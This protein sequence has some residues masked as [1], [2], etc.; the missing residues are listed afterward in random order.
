MNNFEL[1]AKGS[2]APE[3]TG[4]GGYA[5]LP[6]DLR[7]REI[8]SA[9]SNIQNPPLSENDVIPKLGTSCIFNGT[10][11]MGK[12]TLLANLVSDERFYGYN[13]KMTFDH[14]FLFSPTAEGDDVQKKY[15]IDE[16]NTFT[17]LL[18]APYIIG[19]IMEEQKKMVKEYGSD[20][21]PQ[22]L[23]IYDDVISNPDFMRADEFI[24]SF[25]ASRHYNLTTMIC[26]QSWTAVPRRCRLQARNIFF[27]ASPQS[28]VELLALEHCPPRYSKK[29]F[30]SLVN[31]A[32]Y[33]PY[34][35]L[36]IN[37]SAQMK[38]RYHK[39]LDEIIDL[40]AFRKRVSQNNEH[41]SQLDDIFN[42]APDSDINNNSDINNGQMAAQSRTRK[43]SSRRE[44][45][46][47]VKRRKIGRDE[48]RGQ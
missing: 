30:M 33:E 11:G 36:Y 3:D 39:N 26:S 10:T 29:Q 37:K 46:E 1:T 28:E 4:R 8:P 7:I 25:I 43:P 23:I 40:D 14:R 45:A 18:E 42:T 12:S 31:W 16:G 2:E 9:K 15:S 17:D 21:A 19:V 22:V 20:K 35:F 32:T 44:G 34:S 6:Q 27:F 13:E 47:D 48:G 5:G 38:D 41:E 24:K